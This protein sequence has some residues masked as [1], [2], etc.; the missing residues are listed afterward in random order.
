MPLKIFLTILVTTAKCRMCI[1]RSLH[2]KTYLRSTMS[3]P[4]L[5]HVML[6]HIH[7]ER[8]D[9]LYLVQFARD[10]ISVNDRRVVYVGQLYM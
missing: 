1:F 8:T 5:N 7:K 6:L 3:Q 10:F 9:S 2:L 4:R